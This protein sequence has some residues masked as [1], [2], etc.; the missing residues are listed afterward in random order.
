MPDWREELVHAVDTW[1]RVER[2]GAARP[3]Q[4]RMLAAA[5]PD[6]DDGWF[7]VDLRGRSSDLTGYEALRLAP[8]GSKRPET[9]HLVEEVVEE[10]DIIRVRTGRFV[11]GDDLCLYGSARPKGFLIEKLRDGLQAL[12]DPGLA[13]A[14]AHG[15]LTTLPPPAPESRL[16]GLNP[17]QRQA[18]AACTAPRGLFLVWGPPG[19]GKTEVLRRAILDL[20]AGG[21]RVLLLSNANVAVDNALLGVARDGQF[22]RGEL[23]R[24]GPPALRAIADNPA[25]SLPLLAAAVQSEVAEKR[26]QV[27]QRLC[28]LRDAVAKLERLDAELAGYDHTAYEEARRLLDREREIT[29]LAARLHELSGELDGARAADEKARADLAANEAAWEEITA[30]R[31]H[32]AQAA[33]LVR[34]L[35]DLEIAYGDEQVALHRAERELGE[36][37]TAIRELESQP[38]GQ[39]RNL[40]RLRRLRQRQDSQRRDRDARARRCA[41]LGQMLPRQRAVL[42]QRIAEHRR[43]AGP[44]DESEVERRRKSLDQARSEAETA[45]RNLQG[46]E[47]R[48][49][50][51]RESLL[52]AEAAP[53]ASAEHRRLVAEA[54]QAGLPARHA[55]RERLRRQVAAEQPQRD[56]LERDYQRLTQQLEELRRDAERKII[57]QARL[58]ATT[59]ARFRL[60]PA[61]SGGEYD[62]VLVDEVATATLPEVLLAVAKAKK[63]AVL[64]GDFLQLPSPALSRLRASQEGKENPYV[65]KWVLRD[66]FAACGITTPQQAQRSAGCAVLGLQYRFG[67]GIM[68]LANR[69]MYRGL[70]R[71]GRELPPRDP[72]DPEIVWLDTDELDDLAIVRRVKPTSGWWPAGSLL[73]RILAQHHRD[74]GESVGVIAPYTYQIEATAEALRDVEATGTAFGTEVST[75]HSAQGREFDVVVFDLVE[76]GQRDGWVAKGQ[77][78]SAEDYARSG[79]QLFN[80]GLTRAQSRLYLIGSG[81]TLSRAAPGSVLAA[82]RGLVDAGRVHWLAATEL[83][84]PS[85]DPARV[86]DPLAHELADVL[87]QYVRIADIHDEL[88]FYATFEEYLGQARREVY[89]W[90]PWT[91][92][93]RMRRVL[94]LLEA[95]V[96]R[97]V[98]LTVFVRGSE[99]GSMQREDFQQWLTELRRTVPRVVRVRSMH[100]KL[101]VIDERLTLFGSLNPLSHSNTRE[102]MCIVEGHR[103]AAKMLEH[104]HAREFSA[105][106]RACGACGHTE[107]ELWRS[108]AKAKNYGWYWRCA[109]R[110][111]RGR[112]ACDWEQRVLLKR[113]NSGS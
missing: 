57:Q 28:A 87:A 17:G 45:L 31:N 67:P 101:I 44:V 83:L 108:M 40:G 95:T 94:P 13:N 61:V 109:K 20:L 53:R 79:A 52:A 39:L 26:R 92:P 16:P 37:E 15:R 51:L 8:R 69:V 103:F 4:W 56:Q 27:E 23:V 72:S 78:T 88:S 107:V 112:Q 19:T 63:T 73:A 10:G 38:F 81:Q 41:E 74:R 29:E 54:E 76:D 6:T 30:A 46:L 104:E 3:G 82:V 49:A 102:V 105:P 32:L 90:S 96:A 62:V 47:D 113:E 58:V 66:C 50:A 22:G 75:V 5:R 86:E 2:Q 36:T 48:V 7:V 14:L 1:L 110:D 89:L 68:E 21:R 80:V 42:Q 91:A 97:G 100:Q 24:V 33:A 43:L 65:Q 59:L 98:E 111:E 34:Q 25:V 85:D 77:A 60:H 18:Y 55:E 11:T 35:E 12:T 84:A 64:L 93:G 71:A 106:P 70:L 99:D 9:G